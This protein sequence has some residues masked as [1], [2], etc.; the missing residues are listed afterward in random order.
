MPF[1]EPDAL[2]RLYR[3]YAPA[4]LLYARQWPGK[5]EDFVH[6]AFVQLAA[7][8]A[9][10]GAGAALAIS[11]GPQRRPRRARATVRRRRREGEISAPKH[12][13]PA[14]MTNWTPRR[15]SVVLADCR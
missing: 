4:L 11:S 8:V 10:A 1:I 7:T 14:S 9:D 3:Q 12:G 6:D 5:G 2:G 15:P 13:S